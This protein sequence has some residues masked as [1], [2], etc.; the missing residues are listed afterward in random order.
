MVSQREGGRKS[1]FLLVD[2]A[3]VWVNFSSREAYQQRGWLVSRRNR[4]HGFRL[5]LAKCL[6]SLQ[7][8]GSELRPKSSFSVSQTMA[9]NGLYLVSK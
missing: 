7:S 5:L 3:T 9:A 1:G 6:D 2:R 4:V 8:Q